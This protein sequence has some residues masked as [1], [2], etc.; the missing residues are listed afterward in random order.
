VSGIES[1]ASIQQAIQRGESPVIFRPV[2][3]QVEK[4]LKNPQQEP[5][6][7]VHQVGGELD[8]VTIT[9]FQQL[10]FEKGMKLVVFLERQQAPSPVDWDFSWAY[11]IR[12]NT[13][14]SVWDQESLAVDQLLNT[15][16]A[17][18]E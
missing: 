7:T 17:A 10:E 5:V 16:S 14:Y 6:L 9:G 3:L 12:G 18:T 8:G 13:A 4:Y 1:P 2:T 15:A 11:V